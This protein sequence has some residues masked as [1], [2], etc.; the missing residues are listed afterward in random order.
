MSLPGRPRLF[1]ALIRVEVRQWHG[2]SLLGRRMSACPP[3]F[4]RLYA[5]AMQE[6]AVANKRRGEP[7]YAGWDRRAARTALAWADAL[8]AQVA[9]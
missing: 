5:L 4:L 1:D 7:G 9:A 8:E 2:R 3:R 6:R